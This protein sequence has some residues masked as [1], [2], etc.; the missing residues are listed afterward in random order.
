KPR[1]QR[2]KI[3]LAWVSGASSGYVMRVA[4]ALRRIGYS[5]EVDV[6]G[7]R[8]PAAIEYALKNGMR[9]LVIIGEREEEE[10]KI[11][12]KDLERGIQQEVSL[13]DENRIRE[14]LS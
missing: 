6:R 5:V 1:P 11:S 4:H 10:G 3:F 9:Y 13:G 2:P 12:I 8:V 14:V 7:R